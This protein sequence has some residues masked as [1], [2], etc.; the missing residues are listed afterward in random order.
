MKASNQSRQLYTPTP[1]VAGYANEGYVMKHFDEMAAA[2]WAI[3]ERGFCVVDGISY[4]VC[5][6]VIVALS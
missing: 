5:I 3:E 4:P 1:A 6:N 2:F